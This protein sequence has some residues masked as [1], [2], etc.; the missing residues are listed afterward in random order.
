MMNG[1]A[2][3]PAAPGAILAGLL[4]AAAVGVGRGDD[5][6]GES[7]LRPV[8]EGFEPTE[9]APH[10]AGNAYAPA[11]LIEGDVARMWY[12]AQGQDGHD[13]IHLAES[14]GGEAWERR[15]VVLDVGA[16]NHV[17]DPSVVKV[18]DTYY[19]YYTRALGGVVDE[20]ALATSKDGRAWETRGTVLRPGAAG[21][22]DALLVGRPSVLHDGGTFRMWYDGRKDIPVGAPAPGVA[23]SPTSTRGVGHATSPDGLTWTKHPGNPVL[24][25]DIGGVDVGRLDAGGYV[26]VY[27]SREGTRAAT[28]GDGVNWRERGLLQARSGGDLDRHGHVTP[29]LLA[30]DRGGWTLYCG[31]ARGRSWDRNTI[32]RV[33]IPADRLAAG[34]GGR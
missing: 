29:M 34:G 8:L 20:I 9:A 4:V 22:W 15:G 2:R 11:V 1:P 24:G 16:A 12:G 21:E 5:V 23:T 7:T 17:N 30:D 25:D 27:E 32:A 28:S 18:G 19:L 10:G 13:R 6:P 31:A 33:H 26:M 3:R 14:R